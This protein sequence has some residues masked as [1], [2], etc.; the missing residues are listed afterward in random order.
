MDANQTMAD[1]EEN[2]PE[3]KAYTTPEFF[4]YGDITDLTRTTANPGTIVDA[5]RGGNLKTA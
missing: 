2:K 5:A 1:N 3:K 4:I